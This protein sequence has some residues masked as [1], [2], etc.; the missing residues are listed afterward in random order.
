MAL[1]YLQVEVEDGP[2]HSGDN[3]VQ[4]ERF[5]A[6][7]DGKPFAI[8]I[9]ESDGNPTD[10]AIEAINNRLARL[11]LDQGA[12]LGCL[13]VIDHQRHLPVRLR[14]VE[15]A[16]SS[17][18][19]QKAAD[20][21]ITLVTTSD[22]RCLIPAGAQYKWSAAATRKQL[23]TPGRQY[24]IPNHQLIGRV[25]RVY[26]RSGALS[27]DLAAG[28]SLQLGD[29]LCVRLP[30]SYCEQ[31]VETLQHDHELV[32]RSIGPARVGVATKLCKN[33]VKEGALVF[34]RMPDSM[35]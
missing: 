24:A 30:L 27:I 4:T 25:Y 10:D 2:P 28:E 6:T 20:H 13:C 35:Q 34:K 29:I 7:I 21:Q 18:L 14:S 26:E 3:S 32:E 19:E 31:V 11:R 8:F 5:L 16:I 1:N 15:Q 33:S 9:A 17:E 23:T 22:L 12:E